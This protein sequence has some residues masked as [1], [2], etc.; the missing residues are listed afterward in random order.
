MRHYR[1]SYLLETQFLPAIEWHFFKLRVVPCHNTF[2]H[3][4]AKTLKIEPV[5][6]LSS[7]KDGYG[8]ALI[9]GTIGD[10]HEA[11][12]V[13]S[14]GE[15]TQVRTYMLK[16]RPKPFYANYT[17]LTMCNEEMRSKALELASP[18]RI[19]EFV[20][21][22]LSYEP[23]STTVSTT[24]QEVFGQ[25]KGVCQDFAHLMIAMCRAAGMHARYVN[26]LIMGE[27]QTHAWV[28]VSDGK[29]WRAYDPTHN[30]HVKWDYIKIAHGRDADDCATNR[31]RI[32][33]WTRET[34]RV[35]CQLI[36]Q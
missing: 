25:R 21:G 29:V 24:A 34:M 16:G 35:S 13:L 14:E 36:S 23:C 28:E 5:C 3:V 20:H 8:N 18:E 26:G 10:P 27:G 1:Y 6:H 15:V 2:Q 9:Y 19:M 17:R 32:Y 22:H 33:A 12:T 4:L 7:S 30:L 31:G 11:F